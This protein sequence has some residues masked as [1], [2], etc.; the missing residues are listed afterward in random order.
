M[1][2][3]N[4]FAPILYIINKIN[5]TTKHTDS[6]I[7]TNTHQFSIQQLLIQV[8]FLQIKENFL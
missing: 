5:L 7:R 6:D 8:L 2:F 3:T 4:L 1:D